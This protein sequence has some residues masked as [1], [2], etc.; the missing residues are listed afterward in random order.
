M[1][2]LG[3]EKATSRRVDDTPSAPFTALHDTDVDFSADLRFASIS[4]K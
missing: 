4:Q 3:V 1:S 2:T